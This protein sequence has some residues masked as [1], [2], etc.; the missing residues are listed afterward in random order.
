[1][2]INF[3]TGFGGAGF[4]MDIIELDVEVK[5]GTT[6]V[7]SQTLQ[8]PYTMMLN[9]CQQLVNEIANSDKPMKVTMSG[10]KEIELP[11]G[12]WV[13]KPSRLI[14]A[15]NAYTNNFDIEG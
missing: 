14:Y 5:L 13:R 8:A 4:N 7:E 1:M 9:H 15:N 3:G 10:T 12:D 2:R 11:N 6:I